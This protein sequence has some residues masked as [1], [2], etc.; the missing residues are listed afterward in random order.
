MDR[1]RQGNGRRL[2][3][4]ALIVGSSSN[5]TDLLGK[6]RKARYDGPQPDGWL[7]AEA[8][9]PSVQRTR[10]ERDRLGPFVE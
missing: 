6:G 7:S 9:T 2:T 10:Q 8:P 4:K 1:V 5:G 3:G